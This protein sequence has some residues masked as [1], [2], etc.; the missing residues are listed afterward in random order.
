[1]AYT[2]EYNIV[3]SY[4]H[5]GNALVAGHSDWAT[6]LNSMHVSENWLQ[7]SH[8]LR[9]LTHWFDVSNHE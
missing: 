3:I 2:Y 7:K 9:E 4:A 6:P 5:N 8:D 1:M